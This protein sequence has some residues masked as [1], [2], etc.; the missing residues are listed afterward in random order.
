MGKNNCIACVIALKP[1]LGR[2]IAL[3]VK[4]LTCGKKWFLTKYS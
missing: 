4:P 1:V 2:S 3:K